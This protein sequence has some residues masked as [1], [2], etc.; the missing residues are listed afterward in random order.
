[1]DTVFQA[2]DILLPEKTIDMEKWSVIACDQFT[3]EPEY[4]EKVKANVAEHPSTLDMILP[5]VYLGH[6]DHEKQL[7]TIEIFLLRYVSNSL[8]KR[9]SNC[10]GVREA[11]KSRNSFNSPASNSF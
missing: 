10:S 6:D 11:F 8:K 4:W 7:K 3:S 1:M 5:E 9:L 2:A